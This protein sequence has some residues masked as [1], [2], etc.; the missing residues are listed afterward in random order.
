[1]PRGPLNYCSLTLPKVTFLEIS[2]VRFS[3]HQREEVMNIHYKFSK[4]YGA[5]LRL[6][7]SFDVQDHEQYSL[8]SSNPNVQALS[9]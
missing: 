9:T 6:D 4:L 8:L 3:N 5:S 1:M 7:R 2:D